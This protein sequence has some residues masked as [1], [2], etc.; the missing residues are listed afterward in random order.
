MGFSQGYLNRRLNP[1]Q[2][3]TLRCLDLPGLHSVSGHSLSFSGRNRLRLTERSPRLR[4]S[5][6]VKILCLVLATLNLLAA[7]QKLI[8]MTTLGF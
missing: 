3:H 1:V 2:K 8:E 4:M 6:A 7:L 5:A